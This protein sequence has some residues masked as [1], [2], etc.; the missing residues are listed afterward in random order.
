MSKP[1]W[2]PLE[3][4]PDVMN[5]Y[6]ENLGVDMSVLAFSDVYG[7]EPDLLMMVP[8]P[9][10]SLVLLFPITEN[11]E[12]FRKEEEEKKTKEGQTVSD[13]VY[14][15]KQTVGNAC[16]TVGIIHAIANNV[17]K[18]TFKD[19]SVV[20][21]YLDSTKSMTP[22]ERA[23]A[24]EKHEGV[25]RCHGDSA[26][27]GQ[28]KAPSIDEKVDL[29]FIAFVEKDGFLYELDGRKPFPINHGKTSADT[30]LEDTAVV[31]KKFMERDPGNYNFN[32]IALAQKAF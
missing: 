24:L 8:R 26:Q 23:V 32:M 22:D 13:N 25:T 3:S 30:L 17:E 29:H 15:T 31:C 18:L 1:R 14:F 11:Y 10:V 21:D 27:E 7:F 5:K 28:T 9:V 6:T 20:K 4:N 12:N 19:G 2:L 16:G